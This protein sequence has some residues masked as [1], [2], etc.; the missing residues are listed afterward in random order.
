MS[1][2]L[3]NTV[4]NLLD[5]FFA[6]SYQ[7]VPDEALIKQ[8]K[9]VSHRGERDGITV[10]EN[11]LPA[12]RPIKENHIWGIELDVRW[13]KDLV[14]VVIHDADG[15]RVFKKPFVI[16]Q[17]T[18]AECQNELPL[19]PSLEQVVTEFG[20]HCH[21]MIELKQEHYPAPEQQKSILKTVLAPLLPAEDFHI[22]ALD[23][24]L[25]AHVD[26]LPKHALL[27]V[28]TLNAKA[29]SHYALKHQLAGVTGHYLFMN[30]RVIN[31]HHAV[32][33]KVGGGFANSPKVLFREIN[34][35]ADW[36]FSNQALAMHRHLLA[37]LQS[38]Q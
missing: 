34:K 11:T 37:C 22:I 23:C 27:P 9:L 29:F 12:F 3:E 16:A 25:F 21:L 7:T 8:C 18:W 15:L 17:H 10:F 36:I 5:G 2:W 4:L 24:A 1:P 13:T 19:V 20:K 38:K 35:G 28:S 30:S 32:G 14:P 33:Q 6:L 26:F 31:A